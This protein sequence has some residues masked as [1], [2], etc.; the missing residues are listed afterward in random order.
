M[1][2]ISTPIV[3]FGDI[4]QTTISNS[5][6]ECQA[7]FHDWDRANQ[8]FFDAEKESK[9]IL[10]AEEP[11]GGTFKLLG[12]SFDAQLLFPLADERVDDTRQAH[13]ASRLTPL[14]YNSAT[15][16]TLVTKCSA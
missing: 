10:S 4:P 1:Q 14:V 16:M 9:H 11:Q 8:V 2:T 6:D 5:M 13:A 15:P 12:I 3:Y 7:Q